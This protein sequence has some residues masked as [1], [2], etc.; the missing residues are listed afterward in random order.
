MALAWSVALPRLR[1][2]QLNFDW[3]PIKGREQY[4]RP[5]TPMNH[6]CVILEQLRRCAP[7]LEC[8]TLWWHD[9]EMLLTHST[10]PWSSVRE[11]NMLVETGKGNIPSAPLIG[12]L[13]T[14]MAFPQ[15]RSLG[16]SSS[17]RARST[18]SARRVDSLVARWSRFCL[19]ELHHLA[20][21]SI[22]FVPSIARQDSAR[23][24]LHA[25]RETPVLERWTASTGEDH[26]RSERRGYHL[27]LTT[28]A[29]FHTERLFSSVFADTMLPSSSLDSLLSLIFRVNTGGKSRE[30]IC[31]SWDQTI[32][33]GE[34]V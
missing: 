22:L 13:P 25:A 1:S 32:L 29:G 24:T 27:A 9:V 18:G 21:Q 26:H 10:L 2:L 11:L 3:N 8:L 5:V 12:Q 6:R 28:A 31:I 14:K 20:S 4:D 17:F 23:H 7:A 30:F 15:L 19:V 16:W 33:R 34:G